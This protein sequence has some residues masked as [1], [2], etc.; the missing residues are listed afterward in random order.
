MKNEWYFAE[1]SDLYPID[2]FSL[3]GSYAYRGKNM[4]GREKRGRNGR[5][6]KKGKWVFYDIFFFVRSMLYLRLY[7]GERQSRI[8][9]QLISN[10]ANQ[11]T[12]LGRVPSFFCIH[13]TD[14]VKLLARSGSGWCLGPYSTTLTVRVLWSFVG[15]MWTI[16]HGLLVFARTG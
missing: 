9:A 8:Q 15:E 12:A 5:P 11:L 2:S 4:K 13:S 10:L 3:K 7:Q 1:P 6:V 14:L 16:W